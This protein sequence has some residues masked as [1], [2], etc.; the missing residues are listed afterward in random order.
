M[1]HY[2]ELINRERAGFLQHHDWRRSIL[3]GLL[4]PQDF[5]RAQDSLLP[6]TSFERR[7]DDVSSGKGSMIA[8]R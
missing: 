6:G 3:R 5:D 7:V 1:Y 2:R 4:L 8:A